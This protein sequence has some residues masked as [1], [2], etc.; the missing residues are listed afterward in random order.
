MI[1]NE[2][3]NVYDSPSFLP[4]SS[5]YSIISLRECQGF[6]FN[7]DYFASPYQQVRSLANERKIRALSF[8]RDQGSQNSSSVG[9]SPPTRTL[10][11]QRRHTS[12]HPQRPV[13]HAESTD[14]VAIEDEDDL[15]ADE[16]VGEDEEFFDDIEDVEDTQLEH[17][18]KPENI[19]DEREDPNYEDDFSLDSYSGDTTNTRYTVRVTDIVINEN[20]CDIFPK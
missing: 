18:N 8:T 17:D 11:S 13:L 12:Y 5:S 14:D 4:E 15:T 7:Q 10:T 20:D 16:Y 1:Q 19:T 2:N 9:T 6:I 3:F